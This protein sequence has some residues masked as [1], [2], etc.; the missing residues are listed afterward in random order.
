M[1]ER[2][3]PTPPRV[4][5]DK[6]LEKLS[7][8]VDNLRWLNLAMAAI[9]MSTGGHVL[10]SDQCQQIADPSHRAICEV[11]REGTDD[12]AKG[13]LIAGAAQALATLV[14]FAEDKMK[15][16]KETPAPKDPTPPP[17]S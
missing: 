2:Q 14:G 1:Q 9:L 15:E 11:A 7:G 6:R 10:Y 4:D 5:Q 13:I 8:L 17:T 3:P 12:I 16:Q